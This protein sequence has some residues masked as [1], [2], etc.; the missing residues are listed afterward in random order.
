MPESKENPPV[1]PVKVQGVDPEI[2]KRLFARFA[3]IVKLDPW[4][5]MGEHDFFGIATGQ[6]R[7]EPAFFHFRETDS[8]ENPGLSIAFGWD[9]DA[10]YHYVLA[11][12]D[13]AVMRS[14]EI[15]LV[16]CYL[17]PIADLTP[18]EK[19]IFEAS[20]LPPDAKGR[21]PVFVCYKP[22]W[23]PWTL[24]EGDAAYCADL[25]NQAVG[26]LLRAE[27]DPSLFARRHPG[28]VWIR[29]KNP[30]GDDWTEGF[31]N[32]RPPQDPAPGKEAMPPDDL[33]AKAAA[34]PE[35]IPAVEA[36]VEIVPK[37]AFVNK[38]ALARF[39]KGLIPLGYFFAVCD[40]SV[41]TADATCLGTCVYYPGD[42]WAKLWNAFPTALL[43]FFVECGKRPREIIV[44]SRR[45]MAFLRPLQTRIHFKLTFHG[46]LPHFNAVLTRTR[47]LVDKILADGQ[48]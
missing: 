28:H 47:A 34:L 11:G 39:K 31:L 9:S 43:E 7:H 3:T 36:D 25:L 16:R 10:V 38:D 13:H 2:W 29:A 42:D 5:W 8:S 24:A 35:S 48:G 18:A 4:R 33:I 23:L 17:R 6:T 20:G 30:D 22:G 37:M 19:E 1:A 44:S 15:L 27:T 26:V 14:F 40:T 45:M 41:D 46:E 21:A 12:L 32:I